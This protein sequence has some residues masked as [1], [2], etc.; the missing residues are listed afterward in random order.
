MDLVRRID[1]EDFVRLHA[2]YLAASGGGGQLALPRFMDVVTPFVRGKK[3][4]DARRLKTAFQQ[5]DFRDTNLVSWDEFSM[6]LVDEVLKGGDA[7]GA[8]TA[9]RVDTYNISH[10]V[11]QHAAGKVQHITYVPAWERVA[12]ASSFN[13][14]HHIELV[15]PD[16]FAALRASP[17]QAVAINHITAVPQHNLLVCCNNDISCSFWSLASHMEHDAG[18]GGGGGGRAAGPP[19]YLHRKVCRDELDESMQCFGWHAAG[20]QL[21]SGSQSGALVHWNMHLERMS[22]L[23]RYRPGR[24]D[25]IHTGAIM[26]LLPYGDANLLS[27]S[28]DGTIARF[29]IERGAVEERLAGHSQGVLKMAYSDTAGMVVSVGFESEPHAWILNL[30][31]FKPWKL[32]DKSNPHKADVNFVCCPLNTPQVITA[33]AKGVVKVW[34]IRRFAC[35]QTINPDKYTAVADMAGSSVTRTLLVPTAHKLRRERPVAPPPDTGEKAAPTCSIAFNPIA[36]SL[37]IGGARSTIFLAS[38]QPQDLAVANDAPVSA[39]HYN[40][41]MHMFITAHERS[42]MLWNENGAAAVAYTDI[43]DTEISALCLDH[44][45]RKFFVAS[46]SGRVTG[47]VFMTGE[48]YRD[49]PPVKD[50]VTEMQYSST[51]T[52]KLLFVAGNHETIGVYEDNDRDCKYHRITQPLH[53][54]HAVLRRF[55]SVPVGK[56]TADDVAYVAKQCTIVPANAALEYGTPAGSRG[57]SAAVLVKGIE[58]VAPQLLFDFSLLRLQPAL[59]LMYVATRNVVVAVDTMTYATIHCFVFTC[60]VAVV[61]PLG[62]MPCVAVIDCESRLF[63]LGVRP[64]FHSETL[65]AARKLTLHNPLAERRRVAT[66][67]CFHASRERLIVGDNCGAVSVWSL[68]ALLERSGAVPMN[69]PSTSLGNYVLHKKHALLPLEEAA[70]AVECDTPPQP[71][72]D[73]DVSVVELAVRGAAVSF[74]T[75][76]W[77]DRRVCLWTPEFAPLGDLSQGR[78][79]DP[80]KADP[81][82]VSRHYARHKIGPFG[83][84][85]AEPEA[86]DFTLR[87]FSDLF[88]ELM[89]RSVRRFRGRRARRRQHAEFKVKVDALQKFGT[90]QNAGLNAAQHLA[91]R[92]AR[93]HPEATAFSRKGVNLEA[94][95]HEDLPAPFDMASVAASR[96]TTP[97]AR[98]AWDVLTHEPD[99]SAPPSRSLGEIAT[100]RDATLLSASA[101]GRLPA[102]VAASAPPA[103]LTAARTTRKHPSVPNQPVLN[104]WSVRPTADAG[105]RS[106]PRAPTPP[107]PAAAFLPTR[108]DQ[109][110]SAGTQRDELSVSRAHHERQVALRCHVQ[111]QS[112]TQMH[113]A[114]AQYAAL[115]RDAK[116]E[117]GTARRLH[118]VSARH[119]VMPVIPAPPAKGPSTAR[120]MGGGALAQP[121]TLARAVKTAR[122]G[123]LLAPQRASSTRQQEAYAANTLFSEERVRVHGPLP[124]SA[125]YRA[126]SMPTPA[127]RPDFM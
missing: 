1:E 22:P 81:A 41:A 37:C 3:Q 43:A 68:A 12:R 111:P 14:R 48:V 97:Q 4:G 19:L 18:G 113:E 114:M 80:E 6:H 32:S 100:D 36:R 62:D 7:Q 123:A 13:G 120:A 15:H 125:Q 26:D 55:V 67:G 42:V 57:A 11:K 93:P 51:R 46:R 16:T 86:S 38:T 17:P 28:L 117:V 121:S 127:R 72:H 8:D 63:V 29:N 10:I 78:L 24:R 115:Q 54:M 39:A 69:Y 31:E 98:D 112:L 118:T 27:A 85:D 20:R 103:V 94:A 58:H 110:L 109:A 79:L 59:S 87:D 88:V 25:V 60:D 30:K 40:G 71:V 44:T 52:R 91:A 56:A 89:R 34:D 53:V 116:P 84:C 21:Y 96:A 2:A 61:V 35:V 102:V 107:R 23:D 50:S 45:G 64:W 101:I 49:F 5:I 83:F 65:I 124:P 119:T 106:P 105:R 73:D 126:A 108:P 95:L 47:H 70:D 82:D 74:I 33:D 99:V 90:P 77:G 122:P 9:S 75:A 76:C 92:Q 104:R 66:S